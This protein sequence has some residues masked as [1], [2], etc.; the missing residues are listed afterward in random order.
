MTSQRRKGPLESINLKLDQDQGNH[1][2]RLINDA[3]SILDSMGS[4]VSSKENVK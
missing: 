1:L 2:T 3:K 4:L